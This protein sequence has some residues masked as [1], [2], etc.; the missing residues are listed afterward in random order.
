[1][2]TTDVRDEELSHFLYDGSLVVG[3]S[4]SAFPEAV[5]VDVNGIVSLF[6]GGTRRVKSGQQ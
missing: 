5:N 3:Y 6:V 2:R 1:M 4:V